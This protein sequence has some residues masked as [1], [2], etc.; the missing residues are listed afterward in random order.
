MV[1]MEGHTV[2]SITCLLKFSITTSAVMTV[3]NRPVPD[4]LGSFLAMG[5]AG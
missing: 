1:P 4:L 3:V 2:F 5:L